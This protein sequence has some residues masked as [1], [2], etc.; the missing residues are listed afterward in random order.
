MTLFEMDNSIAEMD[1]I[2]GYVDEVKTDD[3]KHSILQTVISNSNKVKAP[4]IDD[5]KIL[6]PIS[7]GAYGKVFLGCKKDNPDQLFA[8]KVMKKCEMIHKNMASQVVNERNA[9]ALSR[10]PFCV[11]LFYSLQTPLCVYLVM[12]YMIGGD[13]KS[14]LSMYGCFDEHMAAFYSAEVVLALQYLHRHGIVHRDLKPDNMLLSA[15]GHLKLTDFGLSRIALH[16]DLVMED[17]INQTPYQG[18]KIRTPGQLLSLTSHLSFGSND[19][20]PV[21]MKAHR[22]NIT[23]EYESEESH[24]VLS[25]VNSFIA[26]HNES[27]NSSSYYTCKSSTNPTDAEYSVKSDFSFSISK[28]RTCKR[29]NSTEDD[30]ASK[31]LRT[32]LG[33]VSINTQNTQLTQE[34]S[35]L[36]MYGHSSIQHERTPLKGVLKSKCASEDQLWNNVH[37]STP[38]SESA[39]RHSDVVTGIKSTRFTLPVPS[40]MEIRDGLHMDEPAVSPIATPYPNVLRNVNNTPYR[41]PK[42]TRRGK[43]SSDQRILGTPDYLAPELLLKQGHGPA[44]DWWALGV[45]MYEFLTGVLPFNDET[46]QLVFNHILQKDIEWPDGEDALTEAAQTAVDQL[47]TLDPVERPSGPEVQEFPFFSHIDWDKLLEET[48]PFVPQPD[49]IADTS[50]FQARNQM[51]HLKVSNFDL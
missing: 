47:L 9:L 2:N 24:S 17:L 46:P 40:T 11:N 38:V 43:L 49:D 34:I 45:C 1:E 6:K 21:S 50:Y 37:V 35:K 22:L 26:D 13:L 18:S 28:S 4:E 48:P 8:I 15:S 33:E 5:F 42:S 16:R 14:L 25:G 36:D 10:S 23:D 32:P 12:E 19:G 44:V 29:M 51:N 41:T 27:L 3:I 31:R 30:R 7:R 39:R 20:T